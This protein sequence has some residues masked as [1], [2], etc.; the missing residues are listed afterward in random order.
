MPANATLGRPRRPKV[1]SEK[2]VRPTSDQRRAGELGHT[3][4][5]KRRVAGS[6][7]AA[8]PATADV[9]LGE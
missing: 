1:L 4:E 6:R 3:S 2:K 8:N 5:K 9:R 7:G